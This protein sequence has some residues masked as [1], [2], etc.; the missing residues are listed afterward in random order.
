MRKFE[1]KVL[2]SQQG[3][4]LIEIIAVLVILGILAAVAVPKFMNLTEDAQEKALKGALSAG[5]STATLSYSKFILRNNGVVPDD[6]DSTGGVYSWSGTGSAISTT[7]DNDLGDYTAT[8]TYLSGTN[9][10]ISITVTPDAGG[11]GTTDVFD[12]P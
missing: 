2:A 1:R 8:Y 7:I 6:I 10:Q 3:F 9:P 12:L 4:T 11:S 5:F